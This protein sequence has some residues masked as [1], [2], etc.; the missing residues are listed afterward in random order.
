MSRQHRVKAWGR[1]Q[2]LSVYGRPSQSITWGVKGPQPSELL[3]SLAEV[4][5]HK[6]FWPPRSWMEAV[7]FSGRC[8]LPG[9]TKVTV[10]PIRQEVPPACMFLQSYSIA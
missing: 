6:T 2:A 10:R 4:L 9:P 3:G 5:A 7:I 8:L 1:L